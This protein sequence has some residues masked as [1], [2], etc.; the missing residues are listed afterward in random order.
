MQ[1]RRFALPENLSR[2]TIETDHQQLVG[3]VR[4]DEDAIAR[5]HWRRVSRGKFSFPNDVFVWSKLRGQAFG[6]RNTGP[7]WTTKLRPLI[8]SHDRQGPGEKNTK[9]GDGL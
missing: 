1:A 2:L 3:G 9:K 4:G 6:L 5:Q 7:V 8:G